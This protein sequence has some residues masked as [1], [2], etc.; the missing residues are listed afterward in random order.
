MFKPWLSVSDS[1]FSCFG[2][3]GSEEG[4]IIFAYDTRKTDDVKTMYDIL[5][6][7]YEMGKSV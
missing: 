2:E 6:K 5:N 7:V 1:I 3:N 4:G